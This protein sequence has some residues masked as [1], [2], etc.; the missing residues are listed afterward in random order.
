[1]CCPSVL[2]QPSA[3]IDPGPDAARH[4]L[5]LDPVPASVGVARRFLRDVLA[6][7]DSD[8]EQQEKALLLASELVTNAILHARTPVQL[9]VLVDAADVLVSVG[10]R[11]SDGRDLTPRSHSHTRPGGRGLRLVSDLSERWGAVSH[12][13]GKTVWFLLTVESRAVGVG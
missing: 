13:G 8:E 9:G 5:D 1:M 6:G 11:L 2:D 7:A 3:P 12:A 4:H 10:D